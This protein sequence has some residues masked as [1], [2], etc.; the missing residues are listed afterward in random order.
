MSKATKLSSLLDLPFAPIILLT[1]ERVVKLVYDVNPSHITTELLIRT[2]EMNIAVLI[3]AVTEN[4]SHKAEADA[5]QYSRIPFTPLLWKECL[6][7]LIDMSFFLAL[8]RKNSGKKGAAPG[9]NE[10]KTAEGGSE[11]EASKDA[12]RAE[13]S[14][15]KKA[16]PVQPSVPVC[17]MLR[18][19]NHPIS[20]V[21]EGVMLGCLN[22]LTKITYN[23]S[24]SDDAIRSDVA[25]FLELALPQGEC[26]DEMG[27][28]DSVDFILSLL[29]RCLAEH[30]PPILEIATQLLAR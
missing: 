9:K 16:P 10:S 11:A 3:A 4:S 26:G 23:P 2:C 14:E 7:D 8:K 28:D 24:K 5:I 25:V 19:L 13:T 22:S 12:T 27:D 29:R 1:F 21:R 17:V 15:K 18:L 6:T 30:E 20:E